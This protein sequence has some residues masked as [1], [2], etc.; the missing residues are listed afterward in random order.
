[1]SKSYGMERDRLSLL[2]KITNSMTSKLDLGHLLE[3]LS[4]NL[5]SVWTVEKSKAS[6][7]EI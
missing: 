5:L 6:S 4:T 3:T 7:A 1:M 2:L